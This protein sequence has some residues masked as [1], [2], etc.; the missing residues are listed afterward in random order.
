MRLIIYD[1][2]GASMETTL[3][4]I[5]HSSPLYKTSIYFL[6]NLLDVTGELH[7]GKIGTPDVIKARVASGLDVYNPWESYFHA[8]LSEFTLKKILKAYGAEISLPKPLEDTG[9]P[10]GVMVAFSGNPKGKCSRFSMAIT[11][12]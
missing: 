10:K 8:Q 1:L 5:L 11:L 2:K 6:L 9:F 7:I 4:Y 3:Y 12:F